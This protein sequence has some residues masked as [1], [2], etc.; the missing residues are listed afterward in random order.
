M[1]VFIA[2]F[3][4]GNYLWPDC[5]R[6]STVATIDDERVHPF[7]EARDRQGYVEFTIQHLKTA[8]METPTS[9]VASRWYGLADAI[10]ETNGDVWVHREKGQLWWT[11][12]RPDPVQ[13]ALVPS[14]NPQRDGPRLF[15]LHKPCDPWS[16]RTR[17]GGLLSWNAVHPKAQQFLF[18]EGTLQQLSPDNAEYALALIAGA[19]LEPWH[20]LPAWR[21]VTTKR[22]REAAL[23]YD[24]KGKTVWRMV[25]TALNTVAGSNGQEVTR[26][27]KDKQSGFLNKAAFEAY[28]RNLLDDQDGLCA[29]SGIQLQLDGGYEDPELR[30]SLDR[31][32]SSGHYTPGNLQIVCRFINRWKSDGTDPEFRRL[33][34][35]VRATRFE[36]PSR[37]SEGIR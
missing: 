17:N 11:T 21:A 12:S 14:I 18:T 22:K 26:T 31:I 23:S 20:N 2:N 10:A 9:S 15:E 34:E 13:I 5:H 29:I 37:S 35:L 1:K 36:A 30:C 16:D 32:D 28:V 6:R 25:D 4:Q 33:L 24:P 27:L 19:D 8:R 7:W 3:G